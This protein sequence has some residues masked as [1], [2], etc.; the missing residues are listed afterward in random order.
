[1]PL[2]ESTVVARFA[3]RALSHENS[4]CRR[5]VTT[6]AFHQGRPVPSS[7][8]VEGCPAVAECARWRRLESKQG[9]H[10]PWRRFH[11]G[12]KPRFKSISL[13][14]GQV[15]AIPRIHGPQPQRSGFF[16]QYPST[17]SVQA[18]LVRVSS[19]A[20]VCFAIQMQT[21]RQR[22]A[23]AH[24]AWPNPSFKRTCLRHAA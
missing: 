2:H 4:G 5:R 9:G 15:A 10:V 18:S 19:P 14:R 23:A 6:E 24:R 12:T 21:Q 8:S 22:T 1:M 3:A 13:S 7:S 16:S 20:L 17:V 11:L